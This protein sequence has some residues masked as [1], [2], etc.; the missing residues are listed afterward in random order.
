M[1][2]MKSLITVI[3]L[4]LVST[5]VLAAESAVTNA[6]VGNAD[7]GKA[8][9]ATCAACHGA[10]GNSA[11]ADYPKLAGQHT[12]Y[13]E[14]SLKAYRDG[15][16]ANAIMA[17]MAAPLSD[18]D[19]A[20]LAAYFSTQAT[21]AGAVEADLVVRGEQLYRFG[22][23]E[24]SVSAC[25]ACHGPTGAGIASAGFPSLKGQWAGYSEAQ[26]KAFRDGIRVNAMMNGVAK[27]MSDA[28]IKAV[29]S[30]AGG[31]Q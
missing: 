27:N 30:Y 8:K 18:E 5:V 29:A 13:L 25:A 16:R 22:D 31:L 7:Q 23:S 10:D 28:D 20:D 12:T 1:K 17:G 4:T 19:I 14:S 21:S 9:S 24:K 15:S 11:A 3:G 26:L 6:Y 2:R